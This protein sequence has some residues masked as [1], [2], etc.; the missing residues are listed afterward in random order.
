MPEELYLARAKREHE[1][2]RLEV[3]QQENNE[4]VTYTPPRERRSPFE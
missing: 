1:R 4:E 2:I 3:W